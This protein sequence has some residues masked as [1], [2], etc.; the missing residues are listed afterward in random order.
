MTTISTTDTAKLVRQELIKVFGKA[1]KFSVTSRGYSSISV[2]WT[3]GPTEKEVDKAIGHFC[4]GDFDSMDDS[5]HYDGSPYANQYIF[6][7]RTVSEA[8]WVEVSGIMVEQFPQILTEG[9]FDFER[10]SWYATTPRTNQVDWD[11][12]YRQAVWNYDAQTGQFIVTDLLNGYTPDNWQHHE[13]PAPEP[14][15][16][17]TAPAPVVYDP[18]VITP[19]A[20][21]KPKV[22]IFVQAKFGKLNKQGDI[23]EYEAQT[24]DPKE[25]DLERCKV[26]KIVTLSPEGYDTFAHNLLEGFDWL[27]GEGGS[28]SAEDFP[29]DLGTWT[30]ADYERYRATYWIKVVAVQAAQ[31][32]PIYANPEGHTYARYVGLPA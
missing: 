21:G 19:L 12:L 1:T 7:N 11:R 28:E 6:A 31:R 9:R 23:S 29:E 2:R 20:I 13:N 30:P 25:Y 5:Y 16:E 3:D 15:P 32:P 18:V 24:T 10:G 14:E 4:T 22:D 26:E 8:V 17:Y 27:A